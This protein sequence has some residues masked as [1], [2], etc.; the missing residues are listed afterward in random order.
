MKRAMGRRLSL[1]MRMRAGMAM[2]VGNRQRMMEIVAPA[3]NA[4]GLA[5]LN[6][7]LL[8][9]SGPAIVQALRI[10]ADPSGHPVVFSCTAGKDRTGLLTAIILLLLGA[11]HD[12][13]IEDYA[14]S[15]EHLEHF[16]SEASVVG[17]LS[18]SGLDPLVF[19]AAHPKT[20]AETLHHLHIDCGG[21][22]NW[23]MQHGFDSE[24]QVRLVQGLRVSEA[25]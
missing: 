9:E 12:E 21:V 24:E 18:E 17:M 22:H 14:R 11:S 19:L 25:L 15:H 4:V 6:E 8:A 3:L 5:G 13:I 7:I 16:L 20:M 2:V 1:G 23:L 10:V